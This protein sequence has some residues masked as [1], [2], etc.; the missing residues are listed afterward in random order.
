MSGQHSAPR[1]L[2]A[3]ELVVAHHRTRA[4]EFLEAARGVRSLDRAQPFSVSP[5]AGSDPLAWAQWAL[6][7]RANVSGVWYA[8]LTAPW[9]YATGLRVHRDDIRSD[10]ES[11]WP[12]GRITRT[13]G[14]LV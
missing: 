1:A 4:T 10:F 8:A 6:L 5:P 2:T 7:Q 3:D 13:H 12:A 11:M 9:A 14:R